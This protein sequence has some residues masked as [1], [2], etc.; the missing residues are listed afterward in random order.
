MK[1]Q[2]KKTE[3]KKPVKKQTKKVN[4][5]KISAADEQVKADIKKAVEKIPGLIAEHLDFN[6]LRQLHLDQPTTIDDGYLETNQNQT[7]ARPDYS[8]HDYQTKKLLMI[9]A[10]IILSLFIFGMWAWNAF[11]AVQDINRSAAKQSGI[12]D[13]AKQSFNAIMNNNQEDINKKFSALQAEKNKNDNEAALKQGLANVISTMMASS[14]VNTTTNT[15][16]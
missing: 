8:G 7:Q 6:P 4:Q 3:N 10:V 13:N 2:T 11:I 5:K 12:W 14:S 1:K 15:K 16:K 9:S